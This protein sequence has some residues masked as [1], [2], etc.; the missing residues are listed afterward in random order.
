[1]T[2]PLWRIEVFGSL[3][4]RQGSHLITRF[5]TQQTGALLAC[6]ALRAGRPVRREELIDLL[7]PDYDQ[8]SGRN[9]LR[10]ALSAL[11]QMF[12]DTLDCDAIGDSA[13]R[14]TTADTPILVADRT[15][16]HLDPQFFTTD[17]AEF[18]AFLVRAAHAHK[19][20]DKAHWIQ[21]ALGVYHADLLPGYDEEWIVGERRHLAGARQIALRRLVMLQAKAGDIQSALDFAHQAVK[22]DPFCEDSLCL[23]MQLYAGT[24]QHEAAAQQYHTLERLLAAECGTRPSMQTRA[25]AAQLGAEETPPSSAGHPSVATLSPVASAAPPPPSASNARFAP[26]SRPHNGNLPT[27]TTRFFGQ[28]DSLA[29]VLDMLNTPH[30][31]LITLT[32]L[33]GSGKTRLALAA[34]EALRE[35]YAGAVWFVPLA[36]ITDPARILDAVA[37][38]LSLPQRHTIP[39]LEQI[40]QAFGASSVMLILDN[41]EHLAELGAQT[42]RALLDAVPHLSCLVTSRQRLNLLGEY[43][44]TVAPLPTPQSAGTPERLL[45]FA[46]V[47]LFLDR[48]QSGRPGFQMTRE[49]AAS[50]AALCHYLEGVPLAIELAAAYVPVMTPAQMLKKLSTRLALPANRSKDAPARHASLRA[51][52]DWSF[53]LLEPSLQRV[54]ARLSVFRGGWSLEA[55]EVLCADGQTEPAFAEQPS[56]RFAVLSSPSMTSDAMEMLMQLRERSLLYTEDTS[57]E[58]RFYMLETVREYAAE[59]LHRHPDNVGGVPA[60]ASEEHLT[61]LRHSA[62]FRELA[63]KAEPHFIESEASVWL[64]RLHQEQENLLAALAFLL[65]ESRFT[66]APQKIP[67]HA[68][69]GLAMAGALWRFW[70]MRGHYDEGRNWL[71]QFLCHAPDAP[72]AS[73]LN[74]LRGLGNLAYEQGDLNRAQSVFE[75]HLRLAKMQG[76]ILDRAAAMANLGN[77]AGRRG[78]GET[79]RQ[80]REQ[81][82]SLY[83]QA[84]DRRSV[85]LLLSNLANFSAQEGCYHEAKARHK[86]CLETF[87]ALEDR[88]NTLVALNNL[89]L[90]LLRC[91][92]E[93]EAGARLRESVKLARELDNKYGYLQTL[94]ILAA[95]LTQRRQYRQAAS[96]L[97]CGETLLDQMRLALD[98]HL[99]A[100]LEAQIISV[101]ESLGDREFDE[102]KSYGRSLS[103]D[104]I[105]ALVGEPVAAPAR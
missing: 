13:M 78:D 59:Q 3:R 1:M 42:V 22:A 21:Q 98:S 90:T 87:R 54:F 8:T 30:T 61:H 97:G 45:E 43:E 31:R 27:P 105:I 67:T 12:V 99:R 66:D 6:L 79:A 76:G 19:E 25:L 63:W 18:D 102:R 104:Q 40:A 80:W 65:D 48:A 91:G 56:H 10:I 84:G 57:E 95:L 9:C 44:F 37:Q 47:Q 94:G 33:G 89:A 103:P 93:I 32:G 20:K 86:E 50:I 16:V 82:L 49:N 71:E 46:S 29:R 101:R 83:R 24:G 73:R 74:A 52:L 100:D 60:N 23:L 92:E 88:Q 70:C 17:K 26:L 38:A 4:V 15:N 34:G 75:E 85:A 53:A 2:T 39:P 64:R 14:K 7:W 41:F 51:M 96:A 36:H 62:F 68:V 58:T 5:R 77:V 69:D 81:S 11:R 55:A 72:A 35:S 28:E